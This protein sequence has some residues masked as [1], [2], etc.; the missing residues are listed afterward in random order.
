MLLVY[1]YVLPGGTSAL[2]DAVFGVSVSH[3]GESIDWL[4]EHV[5]FFPHDDSTKLKLVN[6]CICSE[7]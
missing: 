3:A 1:I 4:H 2:C 5:V 7:W 6:E